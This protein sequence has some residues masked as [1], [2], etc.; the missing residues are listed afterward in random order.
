M[1]L[2]VPPSRH[3]LKGNSPLNKKALAELQGQPA[4]LCS[5]WISCVLFV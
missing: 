2:D 4:R 1:E 5:F 3:G